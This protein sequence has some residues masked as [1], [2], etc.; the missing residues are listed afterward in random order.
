[1]TMIVR[2]EKHAAVTSAVFRCFLSTAFLLPVV[3]PRGRSC[4]ASDE[5][6]L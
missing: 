6:D 2:T 4:R 5:D 1:M 3:K